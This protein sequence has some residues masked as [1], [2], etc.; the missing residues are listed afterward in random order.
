MYLRKRT[1]KLSERQQY[2]YRYFKK[3][4]VTCKRPTQ[5][6]LEKSL[7]SSPQT[8][9]RAITFFCSFRLFQKGS[10][11]NH[12]VGLRRAGELTINIILFLGTSRLQKSWF[13]SLNHSLQGAKLVRI[14][15]ALHVTHRACVARES[16]CQLSIQ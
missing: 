9:A 13:Y 15:Q 14:T 3:N 11:Y 1:N 7:P 2:C 4:V 10:Y 6:F 5:L 12:Y 16:D 8:P